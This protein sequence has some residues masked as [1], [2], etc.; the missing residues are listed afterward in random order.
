MSGLISGISSKLP[1]TWEAPKKKMIQVE[2]T[3]EILSPEAVV[4]VIASIEG[5]VDVI[6]WFE[7]KTYL[8]LGGATFLKEKILKP[9]FQAKSDATL[10]LYSFKDSWNF[11]KTVSQMPVSTPVGAAINKLHKAALCCLCAADFFRYCASI[12]S[13][14]PLY[15]LVS[16][17]LPK[18]QWLFDLSK[19]WP[20]IMKVSALFDNRPSLFDCIQ[21]MDVNAAYSAM[22][23]CEGY[24][25]VRHSV[26]RALDAG[27]KTIQIVFVLPNDEGK[28]Y[29]DFADDIAEMLQSDFQDA[30]KGVNVDIRFCFYAYGTSLEQRNY[31]SNTQPALKPHKI[32]AF[33]DFL[34]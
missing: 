19:D 8:P 6:C 17:A 23:Y 7:G 33:F 2:L 15:S 14:S 28:Y 22:Q 26:Q 31:S 25:L 30:L 9:L 21:E 20:T 11:K 34:K 5:A 4:K 3:K 27:E 16:E 1:L 24:Y 32:P 12:S 13:K 10:C 18:K 29:K